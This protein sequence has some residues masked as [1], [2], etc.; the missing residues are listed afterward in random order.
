MEVQIQQVLQ[1]LSTVLFGL[2]MYYIKD[3]KSSLDGVKD[4]ISH[5]NANIATLLAN[6]NNKDK[7][8]DSHKEMLMELKIENKRL[9]TSIHSM[10]NEFQKN[11][12]ALETE[13][14]I[15]KGNGNNANKEMNHNH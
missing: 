14:R 12:L 8:L 6:D 3:F 10:R 15:L 7:R 11:L 13:V 9:S 4:S 2:A 1:A 5:L